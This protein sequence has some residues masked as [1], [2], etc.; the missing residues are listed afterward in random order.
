MTDAITEPETI[1]NAIHSLEEAFRT[2]FTRLMQ[3]TEDGYKT[4]SAELL[5]W[6]KENL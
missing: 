2:E 6:I 1:G 4:E 5:K 3:F